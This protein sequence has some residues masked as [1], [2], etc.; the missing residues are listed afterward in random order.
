MARKVKEGL[1]YFTLDCNMNDKIKLIEAEFG[2]KA[3]AII[4]K[5]YQKIYSERGYYCEWNEDVALLF[6]ASLGGNSGVSKSLIDVILAASIRR[7]IFSEELYK[8]YG[9][10]TS[11]RIQ[12][13]YFDAVSRREK[14]EVEK[15]YLLVN[16]CKNMVIVSNNSIN[17]NNNTLNVDRNTQS[18]EEKSREENIVSKDTIRQTD[19]QRCVEAWNRLS[20]CGIKPI[21]KMTNSSKRYQSLVARIKEYGI[22]S[23][24]EAINKIKFSK[25]LQGRS[26][27]KRNW[28][29][30]FD[31]FVLPNNFPKVL[32]GN[33]DDN[34]VINPVKDIYRDSEVND[35]F[36]CLD[37]E[38]RVNL[39]NKG[40]I[41]GQ[42]INLGD[43]T[44][45]DIHTLQRAGVL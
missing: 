16:V 14:V 3:F 36:S 35:R 31:W 24:L 29:V 5:L 11:K 2:I 10:L 7:G 4:V 41:V 37:P 26:G 18:R 44:A 12:E 38:L 34:D 25:F 28:V 9:I 42:S 45:E 21:S 20:D 15:E 1:D 30:T 19:V 6:I 8:K 40:I 17:V 32:E 43:A 23:V 33:Y 22:D 13:Q 27:S 39:E